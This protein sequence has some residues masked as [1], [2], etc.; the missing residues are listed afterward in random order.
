M[1]TA[2]PR[3]LVAPM[4]RKV[5]PTLITLQCATRD[6]HP[7]TI[8]LDNA[9]C[10]YVQ[11]NEVI[12]LGTHCH[13]QVIT[14]KAQGQFSTDTLIS[15]ALTQQGEAFDLSDYAFDHTT[16]GAPAF[17]IP[18]E[19]T[20]F[21]H[22]SCRQAHHFSEDAL[23]AA[24]RDLEKHRQ[25]GELGKTLLLASG[26]Q[27]YCDDVAGPMLLAIHQ[28]IKRLG[29]YQE[30]ADIVKRDDIAGTLYGRTPLLP[31]NGWE[32]FPSWHWRHL[33]K[34]DEAHFSSLKAANHLV[35]FDEFIALY[36][37]NYSHVC[38][39]LLDMSALNPDEHTH[40]PAKER[41]TYSRE[42]NN[43]CKF[44]SG[45]KTVARLYA[46]VSIITMF[47]DHDVTDD[48]NLTAAWEQNIHSN[49][50]SR[51]MISN[52]LM[53]YWLFF[54]LGNDGLSHS[55]DLLSEF[56][57]PENNQ[58]QLAQAED[59]FFS[60]GRWHTVLE[61]HPK[62]V[63]LDTRTHRWRNEQ[64]FN[65]PS[66]LM[67]FDHLLELERQ[68][69]GERSVVLVSPAPVFG[70]KSIEAI[71]AI[72]NLCGQPLLVDVENWMAHEGSARK[73][74]SIFKRED[75]AVETIILSGDVHY[76]FCFSV[77]ARFGK[78]D[79]R[80]WQLTASGMKNEFPQGA[81]KWLDKIDSILYAPKSPLNF[82]TKRW[83]MKVKKHD[84][85]QGDTS[86]LV[87]SA[88]IGVITLKDAKLHDYQLLHADGSFTEFLLKDS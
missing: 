40:L 22:G 85:I 19:L 7:V 62:V 49:P 61:T 55:A 4:V 84:V 71:Q 51:R 32:T 64:N 42:F 80:I 30:D 13:W 63:M 58:W 1:M 44:A 2:I 36:L 23:V 70:V 21:Y 37:L 57:K 39:Q 26:D 34:K 27:V 16:D 38:W 8:S 56:P 79:N 68:M 60:F 25:Q 53:A 20:Q 52:G 78:Q 43:L 72:F 18:Q 88:H 9:G 54:G 14:L 59:A 75:T 33:L 3:L 24:T 67:D 17:V 12:A 31:K 86:H 83:Q 74:L 45:L 87:C 82:F 50:L 28:L 10:S 48:W 5:S 69:K 66:G 11:H 6:V 77:Q 47:D 81:L 41:A 73:L 65:E 29:I 46:N 15:Y 35:A 76:G